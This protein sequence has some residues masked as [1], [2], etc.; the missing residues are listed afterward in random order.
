MNSDQVPCT[1]PSES[2]AQAQ[3][4]LERHEAIKYRV[5]EIGEREPTEGSSRFIGAQLDVY[6]PTIDDVDSVM[7]LAY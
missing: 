7:Y 5:G 6:L 1:Q 4:V 3:C 2:V